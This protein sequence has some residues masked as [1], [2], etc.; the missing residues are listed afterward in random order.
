MDVV[1]YRPIGVI[2]T[3]FADPEGTP[4]Q[5]RGAV[6]IKGS[7]ELNPE[8]VP[9]LKDLDGFSHIFLIYHFHLLHGYSLEVQPFMDDQLRGIFATRA[10]VRPNSIGLSVVR[11]IGIKGNI[12]EIEDV[13]MVD[14]T[15]LL[16]IKPFVPVLD[17]REAPS[18]GWFENKVHK[19]TAMTADKRFVGVSDRSG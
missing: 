12:L 16:D 1:Q 13:D 17:H 9:G 3:P 8:F 2:R 14:K 4:I 18:I 6:G 15:P 11:L 7:V 10:P 5:P 19:V